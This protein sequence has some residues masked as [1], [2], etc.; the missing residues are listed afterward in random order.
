MYVSQGDSFTKAN[1]IL[2]SWL[3]VIQVAV[4]L[5][6][7]EM[8]QGCKKVTQSNK[9]ERVVDGEIRNPENLQQ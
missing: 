9:M 3:H 2:D 5:R 7:N 1:I 4:V 6:G 8:K